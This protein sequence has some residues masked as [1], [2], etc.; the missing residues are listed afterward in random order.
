MLG[1]FLANKA[2]STPNLAPQHSSPSGLGVETLYA[3]R[4]PH[5][6]ETHSAKT[7][8][9]RKAEVTAGWKG[10]SQ[11][12]A[13]SRGING[14]EKVKQ[15]PDE[16]CGAGLGVTLK[17]VAMRTGDRD[18][19]ADTAFP[20]SA[21]G[22]GSSRHRGRNVHYTGAPWRLT[23]SRALALQVRPLAT[24]PRTGRGE[25]GSQRERVCR[26]DSPIPKETTLGAPPPSQV[27][28]SGKQWN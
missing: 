10:E 17:A 26:Q 2:A 8:K 4:S 19:H 13:A 21:P 15:P 5:T 14:P 6:R 23:A 20:C 18:K 1:L 7:S 9:A 3:V 24:G 25:P 22:A 27:F 16:L 28:Q 11:N 12:E